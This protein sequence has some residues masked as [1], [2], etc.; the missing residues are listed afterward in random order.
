LEENNFRGHKYI[1]RITTNGILLDLNVINY[2]VN[3]NIMCTI[4]LDGPVFIHD[5]YRV[6]EEGSPTYADVLKNVKK[7]AK[8]YPEYYKNNIKFQ[9]VYSPPFARSI[10]KDYFSK[11]EVRFIDVSIGDCFSNLL[12]NEYGLEMHGFVSKEK[13]EVKPLKMEKMNKDELLN[14]IKYIIS[15]RKYKNIGEINIRNTI[16]PSGFCVPLEHRLFIGASGDFIICERVDENNSLF[17][18]GDVITGYDF[19]KINIL[20]K[21]TNSIL[22]ENCNKCWAFR[23]CPAC[24]ANLDKIEYNGEFCKFCKNEVENDLI[25]FLDFK[26]KNKRFDEIM[27]SISTG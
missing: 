23:F 3:K 20:Y 10:P 8:K 1:Y 9:A 27:Q 26:Y 6:Y 17:Q 25:N 5:R 16:F 14:I 2:F 7:I 22:A 11:S 18:F 13:S 24:F 4:S 15:L 21:H 19:D 12:K